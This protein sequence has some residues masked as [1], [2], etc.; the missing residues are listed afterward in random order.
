MADYIDRQA[1]VEAVQDVINDPNCPVFVAAA[2]EQIL[3]EAPTANVREDVQ[4]KWG[5]DDCC[6]NCGQ[7]AEY[8]WERGIHF[9]SKFCP[10][11]GARMKGD[12]KK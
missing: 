12:N 10:E 6:T 2:I 9:Y 1:V 3:L 8:N 5:N 11:C 4:A 7:E